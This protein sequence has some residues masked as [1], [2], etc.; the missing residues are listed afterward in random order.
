MTVNTLLAQ[1]AVL[2]QFQ[3]SN[4]IF[5]ANNGT[6]VLNSA[7]GSI[8]STKGTIGGFNISE[9]SLNNADGASSIIIGNKSDSL[10][11]ILNDTNAAIYVSNSGSGNAAITAVGT[12]NAEAINS[13]GECSFYTYGTSKMINIAGLALSTQTGTSFSRTSTTSHAPA[14]AWVDFLI[15]SGNVVLPSASSCPGKILFVRCSANSHT[16]TSSSTIY[17]GSTST[18]ADASL[19]RTGSFFFISNGTAWYS[20]SCYY[21]N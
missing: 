10:S 5:T 8:T 6:L 11:V 2:G 4:N 9:T 12:S 17:S 18:V 14:T 15:T 13:E 19:G 3:V 16:I 21:S 1:N 20:F 7:N